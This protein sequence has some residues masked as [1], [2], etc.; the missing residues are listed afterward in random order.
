MSLPLLRESHRP[1]LIVHPR[2]RVLKL[3]RQVD[4]LVVLWN[5][6]HLVA[7]WTIKRLGIRRGMCISLAALRTWQAPLRAI[8]RL[9]WWTEMFPL[10]VLSEVI[11]QCCQNILVTKSTR[12][13]SMIKWK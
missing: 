9:D 12:N 10:P 4:L 3:T 13:R 5:P 6:Y 2:I 1:R 11:K 7:A 8:Y